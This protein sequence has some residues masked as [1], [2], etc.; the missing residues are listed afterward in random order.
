MTTTAPVT[1]RSKSKAKTRWIVAALIAVALVVAATVVGVALLGTQDS[2]ADSQTEKLVR[3]YLDAVVDGDIEAAMDM[4]GTANVASEVLLTNAVYRNT[5]NRI[6]SFRILAT[7]PADIP[8]ATWVTV[9]T[10]QESGTATT[11]FTVRS[12]KDGRLRLL[13]ASLGYLDVLPGPDGA[14]PTVNLA[15]VPE[16]HAV[17]LHA[18][19]G[20]Y[21]LTGTST[22]DFEVAPTTTTLTGFAAHGAV[23]PSAALTDRGRE[24]ISAAAVSYLADCAERGDRA[25]SP[26]CPFSIDTSDTWWTSSRWIVGNPSVAVSE[27]RPDCAPPGG[28]SFASA[29]CWLVD[30][31]PVSITFRA[32]NADGSSDSEPGTVAVHG[33]VRGFTS[34]GAEFHSYPYRG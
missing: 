3:D 22:V 6:T 26:D 31:D 32:T 27:W 33:W 11:T 15:T 28:Y 2:A 34:D 7:G 25:V 5:S 30:S 13:P 16:G 23:T 17:T 24:A 14:V 4:D 1:A 18:F 29:G 8:E 20:T 10:V 21:T 19:P 12:A 9:R